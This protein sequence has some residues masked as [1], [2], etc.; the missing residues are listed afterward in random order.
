[1]HLFVQIFSST[2][3]ATIFD[4]LF[5]PCVVSMQER[6]AWLNLCRFAIN[7]MEC[8][9]SFICLL[10]INGDRNKIIL[11]IILFLGSL[12]KENITNWYRISIA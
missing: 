6:L 2:R 4:Y 1:M 7:R 10:I 8:L 12:V 11:K 3:P 9:I 5:E